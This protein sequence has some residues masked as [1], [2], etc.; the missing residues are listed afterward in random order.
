MALWSF[1]EFR[2]FNYLISGYFLSA[3]VSKFVSD[4]IFEYLAS[5]RIKSFSKLIESLHVII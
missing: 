5:Q 1:D 3:I 4:F 2:K